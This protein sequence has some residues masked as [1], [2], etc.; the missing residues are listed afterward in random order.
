MKLRNWDMAQYGSSL[1]LLIAFS[2]SPQ[3]AACGESHYPIKDSKFPAAEAKLG[4][5][6]NERI[7]FHGYEVG[8][9]GKP[10][11]DDG[12]P[13]AETGLFIWDVAKDT[14]TKYWD[15]EGPV[16]LCV[17]HDRVSFLLRLKNEEAIRLRV[18]GKLG[19]EKQ[20]RTVGDDWVNSIS[21]R[22]H[23]KNQSGLTRNVCELDCV[24]SM[25]ILTSAPVQT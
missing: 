11:P 1:L 5:L 17:F 22:Y 15:I 3:L 20:I 12:H 13:M 18:M 23:E 8:K 6:D 10:S 16:P 19:E 2:L 7:I 4:W 24:R 25:D 14:V 21:C 9:V